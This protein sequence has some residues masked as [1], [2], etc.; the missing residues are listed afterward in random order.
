MKSGRSLCRFW[1]L[2]QNPTGL[3]L[4]TRDC[5]VAGWA[6]REGAGLGYTRCV[7]WLLAA[8]GWVTAGLGCWLHR[9]GCTRAVHDWAARGG[10][11]L[12]GGGCAR[13][14]QDWAIWTEAAQGWLLGCTGWLLAA[15]CTG[16]GCWLRRGWGWWLRWWFPQDGLNRVTKSDTENKDAIEIEDD[17]NVEDEDENDDNNNED[18]DGDLSGE[19]DGDDN[20]GNSENDA[21]ANVDW[22]INDVNDDDFEDDDEEDD[23]E[24]KQAQPPTKKKK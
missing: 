1:F 2:S 8:Q 20:D 18:E 4:S 13:A 6:A 23:E 5:G 11:W 15:G 9:G 16:A 10:C 14:V 7:C 17:D 24:S 21:E 3:A 22:G 19:E 12:H